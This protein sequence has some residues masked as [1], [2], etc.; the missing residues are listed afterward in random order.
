MK[1]MILILSVIAAVAAAFGIFICCEKLI[2][3]PDY[4]FYQF[5]PLAEQAMIYLT[6]IPIVTLIGVVLGRFDRRRVEALEDMYDLFFI[7]RRL[8]KARLVLIAAWLFS[9]YCCMTSAT[10]VTEDQIICHSFLH[11]SGVI[12]DYD[13]VTHIR[14][15]FGQKRFAVL[16]YKKK[17]NFYYQ[18]ELNKKVKTF[19]IPSV[20]ED[21]E[22]YADETY[23][24]LEDFDKRL[25]N[26]GIPKQSDKKGWESCDLDREYVERFCRIIA[27]HGKS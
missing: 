25:V 20:N 8:G 17:G 21:I 27:F 24:E 22:R 10:V 5:H 13:D 16:E 3:P 11:P 18:I 1:L 19:S 23:L 7:W 12:H 26:L 4:Y 14:A 2:V 15:A 6:V 9:L